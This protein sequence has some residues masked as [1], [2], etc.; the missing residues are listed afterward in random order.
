MLVLF[1]I[2]LSHMIIFNFAKAANVLTSLEDISELRSLS[3]LHLRDNKL[4]KLDG[5]SDKMASLQYINLRWVFV[6]ISLLFLYI[7]V[8]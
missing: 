8:V 5:F 4:E 3:A 2:F 6:I 1:L 7:I